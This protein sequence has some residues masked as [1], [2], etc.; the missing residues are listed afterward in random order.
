MDSP[1][2]QALLKK[3]QGDDVVIKTPKGVVNYFVQRVQYKPFI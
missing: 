2:A 3:H 1:V